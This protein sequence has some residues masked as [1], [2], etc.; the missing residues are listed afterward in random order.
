MIIQER[1]RQYR[2]LHA[3][4]NHNEKAVDRAI[5]EGTIKDAE[6]PPDFASPVSEMGDPVG[7]WL[8]RNTKTSLSIPLVPLHHTEVDLWEPLDVRDRTGNRF[9]SAAIDRATGDL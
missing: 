4:W 7:A 9:A 1:Y 2:R 8:V 5:K 6:R 3:S